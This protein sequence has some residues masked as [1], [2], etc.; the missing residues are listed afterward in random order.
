MIRNGFKLSLIH[1]YCIF[2][3]IAFNFLLYHW[4]Y[5]QL[6]I[7]AMLTSYYS[8]HI[9]PN[10]RSIFIYSMGHLGYCHLLRVINSADGHLLD[11]ST[12]IMPKIKLIGNTFNE[13]SFPSILEYFSYCFFFP[14]VLA[15]PTMSH[16]QFKNAISGSILRKFKEFLAE[17]SCNLCYMGFG[18]VF[19]N[20]KEDWTPCKNVNPIKYE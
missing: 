20:G 14:T 4:F 15:G 5:V 16:D 6:I 3:G 19:E 13:K 7:Q 8:G 18:G 17:A 2:I 11:I 10:I 1:V 9:S 12:M